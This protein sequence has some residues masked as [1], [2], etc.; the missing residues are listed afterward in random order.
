LL[1]IT[2][3]LD[4][5]DLLA[6]VLLLLLLTLVSIAPLGIPIACLLFVLIPLF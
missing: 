2:L 6:L 3:L 5:E 1:V 4:V